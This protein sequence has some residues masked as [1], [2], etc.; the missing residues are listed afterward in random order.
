M[1]LWQGTRDWDKVVKQF[2]H[3]FAFAD[4]QLTIDVMLQTIKEKIFVEIL[5]EVASSH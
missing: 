4:E 1:E 3:T 5:I 2:V